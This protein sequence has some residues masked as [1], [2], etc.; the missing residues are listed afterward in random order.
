MLTVYLELK[1]MASILPGDFRRLILK[2]LKIKR[3]L[4]SNKLIY[5]I[6]A[7]VHKVW[8]FIFLDIASG[9]TIS[10]NSVKYEPPKKLALP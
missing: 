10:L 3:D 9:K 1:Y 2:L 5:S 7:Q 8:I 4:F 6:P